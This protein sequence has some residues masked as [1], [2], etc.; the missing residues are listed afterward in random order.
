MKQNKSKLRRFRDFFIGFLTAVLM[1]ALIT[2]VAA[3]VGKKSV[4]MVYDD[5]KVNIDGNPVI[6]TDLEGREIEPVM[7]N[8]TLYV[9]MSPMARQFG[10]TS[11]YDS[12]GISK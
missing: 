11:V 6:L 9:P 1:L 4:T 3:T 8:D 2:T 5:I 10:K 12:I 7:I